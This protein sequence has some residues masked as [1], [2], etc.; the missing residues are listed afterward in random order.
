ME[1]NEKLLEF[2]KEH[3]EIKLWMEPGRFM[4]A[5]AGVIVSRVTQI[6]HKEEVIFV[7]IDVGFNT[8]IRPILY[9][10]HHVKKFFFLFETFFFFFDT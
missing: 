5:L 6:K 1:M 10:A 8:L 7:G 4:V 9:G 3:P 2:K